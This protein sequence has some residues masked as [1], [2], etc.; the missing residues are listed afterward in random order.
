MA[1]RDAVRATN[2]QLQSL[3]PVLNAPSVAA[4]FTSSSTVRATAR[5]QGGQFWVIAGSSENQS[6]TGSF[7]IPCVGNA[8]AT[9]VD[10]GRTIPVIDGSFTDSFADGNAVHIYRID[11]GSNCGLGSG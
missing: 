11:G 9:V 2:A 1:V 10:E 8:T 3:A 5:W 7:S 6:S 4:G